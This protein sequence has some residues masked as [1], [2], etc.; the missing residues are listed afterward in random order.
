MTFSSF[1][2]AVKGVVEKETGREIVL[3]E[4]EETPD[5]LKSQCLSSYLAGLGFIVDEKRTDV[6]LRRNAEEAFEKIRVKSG[7]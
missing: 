1:A 5:F 2:Q 3:E 6:A 4:I 7:M